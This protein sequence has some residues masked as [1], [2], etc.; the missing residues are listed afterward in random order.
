MNHGCEIYDLCNAT[1]GT[2]MCPLKVAEHIRL[3]C[4]HGSVHPEWLLVLQLLCAIFTTTLG[5]LTQ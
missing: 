5:E 4:G 1:V 2:N 3:V